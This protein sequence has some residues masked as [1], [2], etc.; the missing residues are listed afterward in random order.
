MGMPESCYDVRT[1]HLSGNSFAL[2]THSRIAA[3]QSLTLYALSG[4]ARKGILFPDIS[5]SW[6]YH[7]LPTGSDVFSITQHGVSIISQL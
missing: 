7:F 3:R 1:A 5:R 2:G 6:Q 4:A